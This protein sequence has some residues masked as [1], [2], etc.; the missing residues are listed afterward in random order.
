MIS[1]LD[2]FRDKMPYRWCNRLAPLTKAAFRGPGVNSRVLFLEL[3]GE[4][5]DL[6]SQ[7]LLKTGEDLA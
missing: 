2:R 1:L 6:H 3:I 5:F 4:H 7:G